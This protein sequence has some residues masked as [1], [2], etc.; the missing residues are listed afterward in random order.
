M[1]DKTFYQ[2]FMQEWEEWVKNGESCEINDP[3]KIS[4]EEAAFFNQVGEENFVD[5]AKVLILCLNFYNAALHGNAIKMMFPATK[6]QKKQI[7]QSIATTEN[8]IKM[9]DNQ[10]LAIPVTGEGFE[11]NQDFRNDL[12]QRS[13][14]VLEALKSRIMMFQ[15]NARSS[16][17]ILKKT[18]YKICNEYNIPKGR[19]VKNFIDNLDEY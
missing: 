1:S 7:K 9:L 16:K 15:K 3:Q 2:V 12:S 11:T 18:V 14:K 6:E 10:N 8:F 19:D 4:I 13:Q 17:T 5:T